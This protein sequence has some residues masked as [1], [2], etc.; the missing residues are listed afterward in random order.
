MLDFLKFGDKDLTPLQK[1]WKDA[2]QLQVF[3]FWDNLTAQEEKTLVEHCEEIDVEHMN[4]IYKRTQE[5][6]TEPEIAPFAEVTKTKNNDANTSKWSATGLRLIGEKKVG[7]ILLAGGQGTRLGSS[8]PKGMYDIGLPSH[9]SLFQIQAERLM[10][11]NDMSGAA[12]P[13]YI[14]T[15][16]ATYAPTKAFFEENDYFGHN[17]EDVFFFNQGFL[18]CLT[19]EGEIMLQNRH[20]IARAPDGNGGLYPA[21]AKSGALDD[22]KKRGLQYL[23][24]YCVDNALVKVCDP[25]HIGF[26]ADNGHDATAKVMAKAYAD[27]PVGVFVKKDGKAEVV[28]YSELDPKTAASTDPKTKEF[29]FN[30]GNICIHCFHIDFLIKICEGEY[31][32]M[33][34]HI[35]NKKIP[36]ANKRGD[37]AKPGANNGIKLELF[38]FDVFKFAKSVGLLEIVREDEFAPVKNAPGTKVDSPDSARELINLQSR[39]WLKASGAVVSGDGLVEVSPL[40]SYAGN[41]G[42]KM[43]KGKKFAAPLEVDQARLSEPSCGCVIS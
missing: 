16:V 34:Y 6:V 21:L 22:M 3:E 31:K 14:M 2:D 7:V 25:V 5:K 38:I 27:E 42:L 20:R 29:T 24:V 26:T 23:H 36:F 1:K 37:T 39:R 13:W 28:E 17:P 32:S 41:D 18:P 30:T 9:K 43:V 19:P 12:I 4:E 10:R 15:S 40:V 33:K 35:A 11:L 8:N